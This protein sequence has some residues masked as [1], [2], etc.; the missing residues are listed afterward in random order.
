MSPSDALL[1]GLYNAGGYEQGHAYLRAHAAEITPEFVTGLCDVSMDFQTQ[2]SEPELAAVFGELAVLAALLLGQDADTGRAFYCKGSILMRQGRLREGIALLDE[3]QAYLRSADDSRQLANCLYDMAIAYGKTGDAA[4]ALR[5]LREVLT[6]QHDEKERA[7]TLAFML[8]LA[9]RNGD[10]PNDLIKEVLLTPRTRTIVVRLADDLETKRRICQELKSHWPERQDRELFISS[11]P[12]FLADAD[13][14]FFVADDGPPVPQSW[15]PCACGLVKHYRDTFN[16]RELLG[17]EAAWFADGDTAAHLTVVERLCEGARGLGM[18][19]LCIP[20]RAFAQPATFEALTRRFGAGGLPSIPM[21]GARRGLYSAFTD[22]P[23]TPLFF[24]RCLPI[25]TA[26]ETWDFAGQ[27]AAAGT[28]LYR[29]EGRLTYRSARNAWACTDLAGLAS[30]FFLHGFHTRAGGTFAGTVQ[31]QLLH[32]GYVDQP[33]I[34]F[35]ESADVCAYYATDRYRREEGGLV[36]RI[37][38]AALRRRVHVYDSMATL[39]RVLPLIGGRFYDAIVKVMRALDGDRGDVH[40]SGAFLERC[41]RESRQRV[42][43]FGGGR[44]FG[45]AIDWGKLLT[46]GYL[47]KLTNGGASEAD[48]EVINEEFEMFWNIA[49]G[50]MTRMDTIHAET[51]AAETTDLSRAYFVAF[52]EVRLKLKGA[53]RINQFSV[54]RTFAPALERCAD[55]P[56]HREQRR[57]A[58]PHRIQSN[59]ALRC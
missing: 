59:G 6:C 24:A 41:H 34:S 47:E 57:A 29:G 4:S 17:L 39:R 31:A 5:L 1:Q 13:W 14:R 36:F 40:A 54:L 48:L 45:P 3:A 16:D 53:W 7:D 51:G 44:T 9:A 18:H 11:I 35:S 15:P 38:T 20:E 12:T 23:D 30:H 58:L 8:V 27:L 33:T 55:F 32:Q 10:D 22:A 46:P 26:P 2:Q 28:Q 25:R 37:D 49:L 56:G 50:N 52:D 42:E 21:Q 43:A 19:A